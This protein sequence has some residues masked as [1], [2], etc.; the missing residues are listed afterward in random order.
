VYNAQL[1]INVNRD[2]RVISVNNSFLPGIARAVSSLSPRM[3][4]PAAV[5][6]A[7]QFSGIAAP[8]QLQALQT[9]RGVQQETSVPQAGMSLRPIAG[10]L[11]LLPIR[12][13]EARLVW[14]F[15]IHTLDRRAFLG[16]HGRRQQRPG[17]DALRLGRRR[18][19]PRVPQPG[20]KSEPYEPA[21]ALGRP[22]PGRESS[23]HDRITF[24][25]A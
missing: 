24:R 11:M 16:L 14:N 4:L 8:A 23:Q 1:H 21:A 25:L 12:Q 20:R 19:V 22:R 13:G 10:K 9:P 15:Q 5:N 7:A 18:P 2:G 6:S 3:Q 17:M